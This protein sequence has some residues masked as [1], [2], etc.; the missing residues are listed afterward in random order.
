MHKPLTLFLCAF[1]MWS[2]PA[3]AQIITTF[4]GIGTGGYSGDGGNAGTC[5]FNHP[6]AI[7]AD[8]AGNVYIADRTNNCI[9][10]IAATGI[11]TTIAGTGTGAYSGDGSPATSAE[12]SS[13]S[14]VA[15]DG[16]GNVYIGDAGNNRIRK[17]NVSGIITTVAGNGTYGYNGDN[18]PAANAELAGPRGIALDGAG[19]IY[20]A[21]PG[22]DRIRK[23]STSGM[24][25]TVAGTGTAGYNGDGIPA[26]AAE[27][28]TPYAIACDGAGNLYIGDVDNER[29]RKVNTSGIITTIAGNGTA[30]YNGDGIAATAAELNEPIGVTVDRNGAIYIADGWNGR[31]RQINSSGIIT[32]ISGNGTFGFS[33][34]GGP[35]NQAAL[36][37]PYGVATDTAGNIYIA[38]YANNRIR[39]VTHPT[40]VKPIP[41]AS[42]KIEIY[43]NPCEGA[44]TLHIYSG[45]NEPVQI[46]I[47]NLLGQKI[48]DIPATTNKTLEIQLEAPAGMYFL[49]VITG[50]EVRS[51]KIVVAH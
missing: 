5:E 41:G 32:T 10:K 21:D 9:R 11:I 14:G 2:F 43:P 49:N 46:I 36:N 16:A 44:F 34:D 13:P 12:L 18:L 31:V 17:V 6:Y 26:T 4:A 15:V 33:G 24:I 20:V 19:N 50:R 27:L 25:T 39:Y 3:N 47:T 8:G 40:I 7:A 22:N 42:A 51:E 35:A 28:W 1:F 37:D 38:D 30:G 23:I 45:V 29:I 48:K